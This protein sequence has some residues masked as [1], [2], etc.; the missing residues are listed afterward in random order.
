MVKPPDK[1]ARVTLTL[2]FRVR[3]ALAFKLLYRTKFEIILR[4]HQ[5]GASVEGIKVA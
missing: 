5:F 1:Y 3:I 2:P 4:N